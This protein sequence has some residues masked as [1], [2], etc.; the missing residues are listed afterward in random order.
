M[1]SFILCWLPFFFLY[2]ISPVCPL[3]TEQSNG[4]CIYPAVFSCVFWLG[5]SNSA[6]NPIIYTVFNQDFRRAFHK[7]IKCK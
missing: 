7:I 6:I 1:G 3:C 5:Y 2:S 4:C